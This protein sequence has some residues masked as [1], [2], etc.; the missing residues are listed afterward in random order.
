MNVAQA[1]GVIFQVGVLKDWR[2]GTGEVEK[3]VK[4]LDD[5]AKALGY[6]DRGKYNSACIAHPEEVEKRLKALK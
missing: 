2:P 3:A 1:R 5:V 6:L 4:A